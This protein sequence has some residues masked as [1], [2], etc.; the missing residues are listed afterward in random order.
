MPGKE[1][2]MN[3]HDRLYRSMSKDLKQKMEKHMAKSIGAMLGDNLNWEGVKKLMDPAILSRFSGE[4]GIQVTC[5]ETNNSEQSI[6]DGFLRATL[7]VPRNLLSEDQIVE[8][9]S[10]E[11]ERIHRELEMNGWLFHN[12]PVKD[13][14]L[15]TRYIK[16][17]EDEEAP[18]I[19]D[20]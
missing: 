18:R 20:S 2:E 15:L 4:S 16:M 8:L 6:K 1:P 13:L 12:L 19:G 3:E 5:D 7:S 17:G 11:I 14:E 9:E 10:I